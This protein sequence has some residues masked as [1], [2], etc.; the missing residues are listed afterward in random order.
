MAE[1]ICSQQKDSVH[2]TDESLMVNDSTLFLSLTILGFVLALVTTV[3][4]SALLITIFRESR[5]LLE[6]PPSLLIT[7]LCVSD[8]LLGLIA[9]NLAAVKALY[10]YQQWSLPDKLDL[11]IRLGL[12]LTLFVRSG[13]IVV[14]SCDRYIAVAHTFLYRCVTTKTRFKACIALLWV[15]ASI[16]CSLQLASI[17]EKVITIIYAHTHASVPA[18]LLTVVYI[19]LFG[20]LRK[21]KL[22]LKSV[23]IM[24]KQV[25]DRQRKMII[26]ILIVL[27]MFYATVLP[28]FIA[29]HLLYFC[30]PCEQSLTFKKLEIIFFG[31][32]FLPSAVNPFVY[33]WRE[34]KYRR[35]FKTCLAKRISLRPNLVQC[36]SPGIPVRLTKL[37]HL[38]FSSS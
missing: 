19:K 14:L 8:L 37:I 3:A 31:L 18:M 29:L 10:H 32:L 5:Q 12:G 25:W 13:T 4:N 21:R 30:K 26:T 20:A 6:K 33:A 22:E 35:A 17:P 36:A 16:L 38:N 15:T 7:N 11:V 9:G 24:N 2:T 23:G 27:T 34:S 1:T 28:E